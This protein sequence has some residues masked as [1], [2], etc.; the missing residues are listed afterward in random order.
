MS[1]EVLAWLDWLVRQ[2]TLSIGA[3]DAVET[4]QIAFRALDELAV[5]LDRQNETAV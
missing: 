1:P 4:S 5:E 2:Q 3:P